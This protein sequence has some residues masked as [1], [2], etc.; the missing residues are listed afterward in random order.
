MVSS[1]KPIFVL[2]PGVAHVAAHFQILAEALHAKGHPTEVVSNPTVGPLAATASPNA[3]AANLRRV[4]EEL[5]NNQ[6]KDVVLFCHSYGGMV[7]SQ[8]LN[9]LERNVRAKGG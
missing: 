8:S 6:Q 4:L 5:I 3:D 7:G 2:V 9:S 1:T